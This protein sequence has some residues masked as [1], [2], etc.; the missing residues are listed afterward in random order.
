[1]ESVGKAADK[2][3]REECRKPQRI[4]PVR[5]I[6]I[7]IGPTKSGSNVRDLLGAGQREK[8]KGEEEKR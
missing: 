2:K 5:S 1:M 4:G 8:D 7:A 6:L 3:E